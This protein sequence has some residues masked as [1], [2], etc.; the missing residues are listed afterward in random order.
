VSILNY[1]GRKKQGNYHNPR[2]GMHPFP[3]KQLNQ[4][5]K[6]EGDIDKLQKN[7]NLS[8]FDD[9]RNDVLEADSKVWKAIGKADK[10]RSD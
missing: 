6:I 4:L 10:T 8:K 2:K 3:K 9:I 5:L 1:K 7:I